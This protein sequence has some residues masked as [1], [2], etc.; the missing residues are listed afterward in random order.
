MSLVQSNRPLYQMTASRPGTIVCDVGALA[1]DADTVHALA[2]LQLVAHRCG[3]EIRL[4]HASGELQELLAFVGL[5]EVLRVEPSGQPEQREQ[6]GGVEEE[7]EL[8]DPA[9]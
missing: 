4:S 3:M 7:R 6:G 1:A 9:G 2:R 5:R 8:D